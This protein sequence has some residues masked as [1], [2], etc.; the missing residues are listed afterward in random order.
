VPAAA[1]AGTSSIF[2]T[3][4]ATRFKGKHRDS[5]RMNPIRFCK[6][7][8]SIFTTRPGPIC[9]ATEVLFELKRPAYLAE[10]QRVPAPVQSSEKRLPVSVD[11]RVSPPRHS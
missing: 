6:L 9:L 4:P 11:E 5:T 2:R 1:S 10:L 7:Y 8:Q 3:D